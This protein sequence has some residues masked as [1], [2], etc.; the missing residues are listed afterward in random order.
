M[1][2]AKLST[3]EKA[4]DR[5][6]QENLTQSQLDAQKSAQEATQQFQLELAASNFERANEMWDKQQTA[7]EKDRNLRIAHQGSLALAQMRYM[8]QTEQGRRQMNQKILEAAQDAR[9]KTKVFNQKMDDYRLALQDNWR[10]HVRHPDLSSPEK[11]T[12]VREALRQEI[13]RMNSIGH[14]NLSDDEKFKLKSLVETFQF[15]NWTMKEKGWKPVDPRDGA[16]VI[17]ML[18]GVMEQS[19]AQPVQAMDLFAKELREMYSQ[20]GI[21]A[22]PSSIPIP[23]TN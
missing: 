20:L 15:S 5:A 6:L 8:A 21:P 4:K 2:I 10:L 11:A 22:P 23:G 17:E 14:E 13:D 7:Y 19:A 9:M 3:E 12:I 18:T 16:Q 1:Q